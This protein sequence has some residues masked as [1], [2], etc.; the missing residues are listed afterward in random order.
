MVW[1]YLNQFVCGQMQ[2]DII[3]WDLD[4]FK[5]GQI[6][7]NIGFG[8][9]DCYVILDWY[10]LWMVVFDLFLFFDLFVGW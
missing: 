3:G 4:Q 5:I 8:V 10:G 2:V 6:V 9:V 1:Y 7:G